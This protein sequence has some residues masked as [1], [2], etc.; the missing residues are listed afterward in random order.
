MLLWATN[1][2]LEAEEDCV[3]T[4]KDCNILFVLITWSSANVLVLEL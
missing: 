4:S 2:G 1:D 3:G